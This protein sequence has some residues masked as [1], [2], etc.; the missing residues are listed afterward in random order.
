MRASLFTVFLASAALAAC[1]LPADSGL[2]QPPADASGPAET[3]AVAAPAEL[4]HEVTADD[5][6][7]DFVLSSANTT[8]SEQVGQAVVIQPEIFRSEGEWA[9]I[10]GPVRGADGSPIDWSSTLLAG[11]AAEGMIDGDLGVI[12]LNFADGGWRVVETAIGPTDVPQ[13]GWPDEHHVSPA[14]V[15]MEGG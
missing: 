2:D 7:Y 1:E 14:L 3:G 6:V 15:G 8:L 10:Y 12:L 11:P 9:F 13:A 5:D 4:D